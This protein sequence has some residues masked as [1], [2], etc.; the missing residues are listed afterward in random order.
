MKAS[1]IDL[2]LVLVWIG[3]AFF[4]NVI[5]NMRKETWN[6]AKLKQY[7][8]HMVVLI[9]VLTCITMALIFRIAYLIRESNPHLILP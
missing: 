5:D 8:F 7:D 9:L 2:V 6:K 1:L 3:I 4:I